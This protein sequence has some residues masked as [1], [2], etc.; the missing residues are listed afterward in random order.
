MV[1]SP[2]KQGS[3]KQFPAA[4]QLKGKNIKQEEKNFRQMKKLTND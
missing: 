3:S 1:D 2:N 4:V